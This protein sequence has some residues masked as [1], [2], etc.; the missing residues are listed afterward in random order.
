MR[1]RKIGGGVLLA[2]FPTRYLLAATFMRIQ[3]YYESPWRKFRGRR[4]THEEYMDAYAAR[5][6]NFT[7]T[8]DWGGFNVPGNAVRRFFAL[9][10]DLNR[11][12]A[13]LRDAV[14]PAVR[15]LGARFYLIGAVAG[16]AATVRHE[17]AHGFY[18]LNPQYAAAM[19][20]ITSRWRRAGAFA[21]ALMRRGYARTVVKDE[22]QAYLATSTGAELGFTGAFPPGYR[23]A[24]A[25]FARV[26]KASRKR[27]SNKTVA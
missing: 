19:D 13:A 3:E 2:E 1:L 6:G 26:A 20:A 9:F 21:K 24:F 25:R 5:N 18:Y 8:S 15:G 14:L 12:E 17:M 4:F 7:Y 16:D 11:K 27:E 22:T 10:R 23:I